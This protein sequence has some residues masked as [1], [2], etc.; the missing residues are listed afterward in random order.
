[1]SLQERE[2]I[3]LFEDMD[4]AHAETLVENKVLNCRDGSYVCGLG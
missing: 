2:A 4:K 1:M 3:S